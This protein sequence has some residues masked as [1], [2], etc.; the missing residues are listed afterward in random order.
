MLV[1]DSHSHFGSL[2]SQ[3]FICSCSA[4]ILSSPSSSAYLSSSSSYRSGSL[5][6]G[7]PP[8]PPPSILTPLV[9]M[10]P[11]KGAHNIITSSLPDTL[12]PNL[13]AYVES[14]LG[15]NVGIVAS[16]PLL[17]S[18]V[19]KFGTI[20]NPDIK[21]EV[22]NAAIAQLA[23][24][25]VSYE[26]Q[27]TALKLL[28]ADAYEVNED[29]TGSAKTLQTIT[30][31]SSQKAVSDNEKANI[32]IRITRC[33]LEEED[34]TNALAYLNRIKNVIHS[35]TDPALRI[36]FQAS[37]ARISDSQ[38]NF[39]DASNSY[40]NLSNEL[41]ID[42]EDRLQSLSAAIIC[43][44]LAP[45][46]PKRAKQL[47]R[48]YKD[49]RAS[50]VEEYSI[51]EKIFLDRVLNQDEIKAFSQ[52][53]RP[54]QMAKTADG[55]TVLDKAVLE[56]NLLGVSRLYSNI[57]IANL[58]DMLGVDPER[59]EGYARAM[60]EQGR[61]SGY[62]DQ[63]D[64]LI[65]F[66]PDAEKGGASNAAAVGAKDLR[67]WDNNVQGLAEEVER[68]TTMIQLEHPEFYAQNMVH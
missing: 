12:A 62:I 6:M 35:V 14:I 3:T 30:L 26:A 11:S 68:V 47:A 15:D 60:I 59:A 27:D 56:H 5:L 13:I 24:K 61:L 16:R 22:G 28:V 32:W 42:E 38:R 19:D 31:D 9:A 48:L 58:G 34:P 44:V 52:K 18:F 36:Q 23:P 20:K 7:M 51:L 10:I 49:D 64:E 29:Y 63:I 17:G 33:Y 2:A 4:G 46:G 1:Q 25:V 57:G 43:A 66:E 21:I 65:Y 67:I 41:A 40:L 50:Q 39:L 55:S 45:A 37:Q 54:H 53:L 8:P